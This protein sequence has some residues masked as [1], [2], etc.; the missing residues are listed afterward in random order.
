MIE[1]FVIFQID[2]LYWYMSWTKD[3]ESIEKECKDNI[4]EKDNI[5]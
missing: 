1:I 5:K 3:I 4:I 2:S